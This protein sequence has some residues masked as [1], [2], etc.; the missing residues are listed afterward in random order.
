M[1]KPFIAVFAAIAVFGA[2]GAFAAGPGDGTKK[3]RLSDVRT[4]I[5]EFYAQLCDEEVGVKEIV[6]TF[7]VDGETVTTETEITVTQE[8]DK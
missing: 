2:S 6:S 7:T 4:D 3:Q 1:M 8:C 5:T